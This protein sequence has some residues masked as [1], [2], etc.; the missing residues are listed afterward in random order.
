MIKNIKRSVTIFVAIC[1]VLSSMVI[2]LSVSAAEKTLAVTVESKDVMTGETV[3][4]D[5][6]VTSNPGIT[7]LRL[8]L[9]YDTD[10]LTL[11]NVADVELLSGAVLSDTYTSPYYLVWKDSLAKTDNTATGTIAK[12]TFKVSDTA[13]D[14]DTAD[15]K[16]SLVGAN[17]ILDADLNACALSAT[18]GVLT[19]FNDELKD[20]M[21]ETYVTNP[22]TSIRLEEADADPYVSA[23]IRFK[24]TFSEAQMADAVEIGFAAAPT[25]AILSDND[26]YQFDANGNI[27]NSIAKTVTCYDASSGKHV[28]FDTNIPD[29]G[30]RSYRLIL[31]NLSTK[32]GEK[33]YDLEIAVVMYV[34]TESGYTY[35]RVGSTTYQDVYDY[36][37]ANGM[38]PT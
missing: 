25:K 31:T 14:D 27:N 32:D 23:G 20:V 24:G 1:L 10:M 33:H 11:T 13:V 30:C 38:L 21:P 7:M 8:K 35:Y 26:W 3:E 17:D 22:E 2:T 18:N 34:K 5:V 12:L 36:C 9:E 19:V 6:S 4:V 37:E 15:V 16:V 28:V 29:E